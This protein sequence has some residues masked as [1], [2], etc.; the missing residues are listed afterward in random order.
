MDNFKMIR[1]QDPP[2][3]GEEKEGKGSKG[4]G[5][6]RDVHP[7]KSNEAVLPRQFFNP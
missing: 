1:G 5:R 3:K 6:G 7:P 2:L 4:E